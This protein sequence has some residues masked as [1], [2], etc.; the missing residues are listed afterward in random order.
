MVSNGRERAVEK[1]DEEGEILD[2]FASI[3]E[4]TRNVSRV[5]RGIRSAKE[6]QKSST[7]KIKKLTNKTHTEF[8]TGQ[9]T[10]WGVW[11]LC[12]KWDRYRFDSECTFNHNN[13]HTLY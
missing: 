11:M 4:A 9:Y 2:V 8:M 13:R 6:N 5:P 12:P 7:T 3:Q 1:R 10:V